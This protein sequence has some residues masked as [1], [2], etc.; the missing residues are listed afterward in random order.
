ME[1]EVP[2]VEVGGGGWR[3]WLEVK[4]GDTFGGETFR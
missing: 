3:W 1:V 4:I 2:K